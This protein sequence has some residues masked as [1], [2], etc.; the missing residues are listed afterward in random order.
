MSGA[1]LQSLGA[2]YFAHCVIY[3]QLSPPKQKK[4]QHETP[5]VIEKPDTHTLKL[6]YHY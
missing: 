3:D 5:M 2:V 6:T 4:I 1:R